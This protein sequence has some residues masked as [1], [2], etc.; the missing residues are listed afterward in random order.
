MWQPDIE[1]PILEKLKAKKLASI[2]KHLQTCA[3][4]KQKRKK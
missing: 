2:K 1:N 3:K 4:N